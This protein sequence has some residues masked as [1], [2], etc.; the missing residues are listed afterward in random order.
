MDNAEIYFNLEVLGTFLHCSV[1]K[2]YN[3][4]ALVPSQTF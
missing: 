3:T 2:E 1:S 4:K